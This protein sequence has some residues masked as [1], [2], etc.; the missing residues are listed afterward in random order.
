MGAALTA[1]ESA[2]LA[3]QGRRRSAAR[4]AATSEHPAPPQ[5]HPAAAVRR[6]SRALAVAMSTGHAATR[7]AAGILRRGLDD[8]RG[9]RL[10]LAR[11]QDGPATDAG[12]TRRVDGREPPGRLVMTATDPARTARHAQADPDPWCP[13]SPEPYR[14]E[15]RPQPF[16]PQAEQPVPRPPPDRARYPRLPQQGV[17]PAARAPDAGIGGYTGGSWH[18]VHTGPGAP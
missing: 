4:I 15:Q 5:P 7:L 6:G 8:G 9:D 12:R 3:D 2:A 1:A 10:R 11:S 18:S 16:P 17:Q 14:P 13:N